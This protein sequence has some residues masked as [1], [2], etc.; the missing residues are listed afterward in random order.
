M[1]EKETNKDENE[2]ISETKTRNRLSRKQKLFLTAARANRGN[3]TECCKAAKL[4]RST[5]YKWK[6][7]SDKF[8]EALEEI[9]EEKLDLSES[10][11]I[12]NI[13]AGDQK[14]IQYHL[15]SKG[16]GRGYG[17]PKTLEIGGANGEPLDT[18]F[19]VNLVRPDDKKKDEA[20]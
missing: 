3:V 7:E 5:F 2:Q 14:A 4:P 20:A 16:Q 17:R 9:E 19:T 11:L 6:N 10:K 12:E 13:E 18:V 8:R 1:S 15:D